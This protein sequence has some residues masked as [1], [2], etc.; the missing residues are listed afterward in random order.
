MSLDSVELLRRPCVRL[1]VL[2]AYRQTH[3]VPLADVTPNHPL[4]SNVLPH[5]V[6]QVRLY[7]Q[8]T[9]W[10]HALGLDPWQW[11]RRRIELREVCACPGQILKGS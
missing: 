1:R 7:P 4:V 3:S 2:P 9:E 6:F 5:L 8:P 11:R 10:V